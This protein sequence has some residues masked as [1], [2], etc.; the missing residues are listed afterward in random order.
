MFSPGNNIGSPDSCGAG[1]RRKSGEDCEWSLLDFHSIVLR[2]LPNTL[3]RLYHVQ[4]SHYSVITR[5]GYQLVPR[6]LLTN[7]IHLSYEK[8]VSVKNIIISRY[9]PIVFMN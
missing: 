9:F 8:F 3:T 2:H 1:Q 6:K 7:F 4:A 5:F